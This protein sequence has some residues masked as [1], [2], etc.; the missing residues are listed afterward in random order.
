[1][2]DNVFAQR[3]SAFPETKSPERGTGPGLNPV[4]Q[5]AVDT[6]VPVN[7]LLAAVER[8][9]PDFDPEKVAR[10]T[11]T[12]LK[13]FID[14]GADPETAIRQMVGDDYAAGAL[15]DHAKKIAAQKYPLPKDGGAA[16]PA[17]DQ[18]AA[19]K[20][21]DNQPGFIGDLGRRV[22]GAVVSSGGHML[23]ATGRGLGYDRQF[24]GDFDPA[25][26]DVTMREVEADRFE[27]VVA[28]ADRWRGAGQAISD[29]VS[30][31]TKE[32]L[33]GTNIS[34]NLFKPST[35]DFG[36]A[37]SA[38]GLVMLAGDVL[39][40]LAPVVAA[41][42]ATRGSAA[43]GMV[44]GGL[45]G[46]GA[47]SDQ[48]REIVDAAAA[49]G[50]LQAESSYYKEA[51]AGGASP[52]EALQLTR[53][54]AARVAAE[55]T[56]PISMFGGAATS[57]IMSGAAGN[58]LGQK[59]GGTVAGRVGAGVVASGLEEGV[60][61]VAEGV[62]ARAA[63]NM[64]TG[65]N[66]DVMDGSFADF[67]LGAMGGGPV[68][69]IGGIRRP[70]EEAPGTEPAGPGLPAPEPTLALPP[71]D[72]SE[73]LVGGPQAPAPTPPTGGP[74]ST[75][76][77]GRDVGVGATPTGPLGRAMQSAPAPLLDDVPLGAQVSVQT[78]AGEVARGRIAAKDADSVML[79]SDDGMDFAIPRDQ[80]ESGQVRFTPM[81]RD[82]EITSDVP[83]QGATKVS[84][85]TT[86][87]APREPDPAPDRDQLERR[88]AII[89]DQGRSR[90]WTDERMKLRADTMAALAKL[91]AEGATEGT[92]EPPQGTPG[93]EY[94]V[95]GD[96]DVEVE[97]GTGP[98][99]VSVTREGPWDF[100]A[101]FPS[102][103]PQKLLA[104]DAEGRL[105]PT[106]L[107]PEAVAT[108]LMET[109]GEA[110]GRS[111]EAA[112]WADEAK[113]IREGAKPSFKVKKG[114][115]PE[116]AAEIAAGNAREAVK[117]L[118]DMEGELLSMWPEEAVQAMADR[119]GDMVKQSR[120]ETE[121]APT[122]AKAEPAPKAPAPKVE[123]PAAPVEAEDDAAPAAEPKPRASGPKFGAFKLADNLPDDSY[124]KRQ[125][126]FTGPEL[127]GSDTGYMLGELDSMARRAA[128]HL[129]ERGKEPRD[130]NKGRNIYEQG[131]AEIAQITDLAERILDAAPKDGNFD[132]E[133]ET[134]AA[135]LEE[136]DNL[137]D[138]FEGH[139][140][141]INETDTAQGEPSWNP[142]TPTPEMPAAEIFPPLK[143][144]VAIDTRLKKEGFIPQ[145]DADAL[146]ASWKETAQRI[147]DEVDN[148]KKVVVSLFDY[149]GSW[150]QPWRD[151]GYRVIQHDIKAGANVL[152]DQWI[153]DQITEAR[154]SGFEV[155]GVLSACPC[156]TFAGSGAR[157]W[158]EL[159]DVESPDA[160]AKVFG[161]GALASGAK[162]PVEYN[163]M[164][165]E[166][167][168]DVIAAAAPTRFHVL[169]NPIGRIQEKTG[170]SKPAVRLHPHNFGDAYTKR[171]QL[172]GTMKT[173]LPTANV[174]PVD[175]SKMQSQ[176]RGDDPMGKE[177]RSK[178]PE[179][180][181][182][183]F[184][185]ANDPTARKELGKPID[186]PSKAKTETPRAKPATMEEPKSQ[187][188]L[189][190]KDKAAADMEREENARRA[191]GR[192]G[193][194]LEGGY[195]ADIKEEVAGFFITGHKGRAGG[196][197]DVMDR[198]TGE[199]M[200][201]V[202]ADAPT[203]VIL[204][205]LRQLTGQQKAPAP[206]APKMKEDVV[207]TA[208][209]VRKAAAETV[210]DPSP[211]QAEA[212]NYK[213]GKIGWRGLTLSIENAK[214]S[215]RRKIG[216][217]GE[218][219]WEVKMPAHYGRILGTEGADGDHVDFYMGDDPKAE[220]AFVIDQVDAETGKFDEHKVMLGFATEADARAAYEAGF[221]DG[222]GKDRL[223]GLTAMS[224]ADFG[225]L[226]ADPA[227]WKKPLRA[228]AEK[229]K[230][231]PKDAAPDKD[232]AEYDALAGD[233]D[234][235]KAAVRDL[236]KGSTIQIGRMAYR[237]VN[238]K[239]YVAEYRNGN[240]SWQR[241]RGEK[242]QTDALQAFKRVFTGMAN[243]GIRN[244]VEA[245][246][247][248]AS[249]R[250]K[251]V[252]T[253]KDYDRSEIEDWVASGE[254]V[255]I[256][257]VTIFYK[258]ALPDR[259]RISMAVSYNTPTWSS[260]RTSIDLDRDSG[261]IAYA[262]P[263]QLHESIEEALRDQK[264]IKKDTPAET[265]GEFAGPRVLVNYVGPDGKTDQE[266]GRKLTD[267]ER[268]E[269]TRQNA[270]KAKGGKAEPKTKKRDDYM[271]GVSELELM[272][273]GDPKARQ[274]KLNK[275]YA[276]AKAAVSAVQETMPRGHRLHVK[277]IGVLQHIETTGDGKTKT[278][279]HFTTAGD[280]LE[281]AGEIFREIAQEI[282][283]RVNGAQAQKGWK[284]NKGLSL[285]KQAWANNLERGDGAGDLRG[286]MFPEL[287]DYAD[288]LAARSD[289]EL[290]RLAPQFKDDMNPFH[291]AT[292]LG[293]GG[294]EETQALFREAGIPFFGVEEPGEVT[295]KPA[296]PAKPAYGA[297]NKLVS[298]DRAAELRA[299]LMDK[300]KNQTNAGIDPEILAL[301]AE[302]AVFHIEAGARRFIDMARA[303]S[304]DLSTTPKALKPYLR[305]W[306]NGA[307]DMMEDSDV[308]VEG[309][310]SA[311]T[312]RTILQSGAIDGLEAGKLPEEGLSSMQES[313]DEDSGDD[314][315]ADAGDGGQG[316]GEGAG[317]PEARPRE[318][319][320]LRQDDRDTG[321]DGDRDAERAGDGPGADA[322]GQGA[323]DGAGSGNRAGRR[324]TP[325]DHVIERGA[326]EVSGG[327]K[328]R[329]RNSVAA[330][331]LAKEIEAE[332][333]VA[334]PEERAT[335][336][337]YGGAGTLAPALPRDDGSI[338]FEDVHA[339]IKDLLTDEEYAT[340][341]RT[342]Q[343]AFY[344][345]EPVLRGMWTLAQR[346]GFE[347]GRVFE[348]GMGVGGFAGT[349]PAAIRADTRYRGIELD[350]V[351]ALIAKTLYPRS[352]IAQGDFITMA[353][354]RDYY[355]MVIG[356][357][358]FS[359]T[360]IEAD[361]AYP[362][363]FL[364]HDY[365]FAKSL[366]SV[367]P[368]GLLMFVTSAGTMNKADT[369][370]RDYLADR[371]DL[372]GAIRLPNTA[373]K[374]N[375]TEV[376]TDIIILRKRLEG[377]AEVDPSWRKA[378]VVTLPDRDGGEGQATVNQYFIDH[379]EMILGEQGLY[380]KLAAGPRVGVRALPGADIRKQIA[381]VIERFPSQIMSERTAEQKL[382]ARDGSAT[383]TKTGGYYIKDGQLWQ[384]DGNAG[385]KVEARAKGKTGKT[386]AAID[387]IMGLVPIKMALRDVYAA[388]VAGKD[389]S[390]ARKRLNDTYDAFVKKFGPINQQVRSERRPSRVQME[391]LRQR[392][393]EDARSAGE[394]FDIGSFDAQ[395]LFDEQ[396][397]SMA[398]VA[399][400]REEARNQPGYRE[401]DFNPD[402]APANIIVTRPN[403]DP[404]M[405][406]QDGYR[407]LAIE[408]YDEVTD[409][410][411]KG[412]VFREN[413]VTKSVTPKIN[414][415]EDAL[416]FTL[417]EFGRVDLEKI[418]HY[419]K[420]D[421]PTV[422]KELA[423][424]VFRDPTTREWQTRAKYLSGNVREKLDAARAAA[425]TNPAYEG[426]VTELEAIQPD[427]IPGEQITVPIGAHWFDAG[428]Y[429]QFAEHLGLRLTATFKPAL[430]TWVVDGSEAGAKATSDYGTEDLPFAKL[431][432][433]VMNNQPLKVTRTAKNPDGST[434]SFTDETATQ[435]A[436]DK[437][438][439]MRD[440]F[441]DW[442]WSDEA[443]K[444]DL[445]DTYNRKFN[446]DVAP[447]FD[448][449]YLTTP[450]I[451]TAWQW[452]PHQ[453]AVI[454][455]ILQ[456]G[457]TYMAH[458]V[459][460][461]KT[462]AAIGA[463]MEARRLGLW[464]KPMIVVPNHMLVQ[465]TKEFYEQYPLAKIAVADEQR[466]HTSRRKAFVADIALNDYDAVIITHSAFEKI[467][468][469]EQARAA[470]VADFLSDI[471]E[472]LEQGGSGDRNADMATERSILYALTSIAKAAGVPVNSIVKEKGRSTRKKIEQIL[473]Q[474]EQRVTR[475]VSTANRDQVVDFE[476]IGVDALIVD[477]VHEFR[478][479]S[480]A[481]SMG[482][483]KGVD[484]AG[485]DKSMDLFVKTR[486][487]EAKNPG[488]GLVFMSGT[489]ITNTM[490]ELFSISRFLQPQEL[491]RRGVAS[492]DAWAATFGEVAEDLEQ[493][494]DGSYKSVARF[495][496]FVNTP[497]LSLMVRQVMDVVSSHDL[498]QYVTRPAL[499]GGSRNLV[500]VPAGPEAKAYQEQLRAR[501]EKIKNHKGPRQKGDD[502]LLNVIGDGRLAA[503][504]MR[505]VDE[506]A[507]GTGSKLSEMVEAIYREWEDGKNVPFYGVKPEGGY[508]DEP[509]SHGPATQIVFSTLG[510]NP[511][512]HNPGF[513]VHRFIRSELIRRG[514]PANEIIVA[515]ELNSHAKKQRAFNDMNEGKRRILI[516][517]RT[518]FTGVNAQ[519]RL[520][521]IHN[522][523]PLWFPADDEQRNGRGIRQG[524]MNREIA[525]NDYSTKG[526]YD[527]TM[528]QMMGRKGAFIEGF[529]RGDPNVRDIEDI[530]EASVFEQAKALTT[531]DPRV[532]QLTELKGQR[533]QL[534][535]RADAVDRQRSR[536]DGRIR[537]S[538]RSIE[539]LTSEIEAWQAAAEKVVDLK[540]KNFTARVGSVETTERVEFGRMLIDLADDALAAG[541]AARQK[542]VAKISG[543]DVLMNTSIAAQSVDFDLR[544][545]SDENIEAGWSDD[546]VG[547]SRR[548]ENA[549]AAIA[550]APA[551]IQRDI[552]RSEATVKES[553]EAL[554]RVKPFED[555][556]KLAEIE[557]QIA[558]IEGAL[559]SDHKKDDDSKE[560]AAD[561]WTEIEAEDAPDP[562]LIQMAVN[563]E[564]RAHGIKGRV[565]A[566]VVAEILSTRTGTPIP[567]VFSTRTGI[568]ISAGSGFDPTSILHHEIIH[569]L[570]SSQLWGRDYGLFDQNEWR[571]LTR[572]ARADA[573]I[574]A[575][576]NQYYPT[577]STA[578]KNEEAVAELY[579]RWRAG[580]GYEARN[581]ER[582]SGIM[583]KIS[584]FFTALASALRGE[585]FHSHADIMD[586]IARGDVGKRAR[587]DSGRFAMAGAREMAAFTDAAPAKSDA[588][589]AKKERTL[590]SNLLTQAMN[591]R[592]GVLALVPGRPLYE[593][594][595]RNIGSA[596]RYLRL[597]E[598]M[599]KVR[600]EWHERTDEVAKS[601]RKVM[602]KDRAANEAMMNLMHEATI[603][604]VD[605]SRPFLPL[606]AATDL[607]AFFAP[608]EGEYGFGAT[609]RLRAINER[610]FAA[611]QEMKP[612]WNA[613]P[614][615]FKDVFRKVRGEH[616]AMGDAF[617]AAIIENVQ[618]SMEI[619][620]D[621]AKDKY[622]K[623]IKEIA[624]MGLRGAALS[625]ATDAAKQELKAAEM[626]HGW[627]KAARI[628]Q[629][630][631][632][633]ETQKVPE[634]YFPLMRFGN[635]FVTVR[636]AEG[637]VLSFSKY[638]TEREQQ[639]AAKEAAKERG[640][641]VTTG[642]IDEDADFR[643]QVDP[644][645]VADIDEILGDAIVDPGVMD[646]IWQRWLMTLPDMSV[647]KSRIHRK[648]TA[649]YSGDAFRA[650]AR[651]LFHGSHQLARLKYAVEM[652]RELEKAET[653]AARSSDPNRNGLI[654]AEMKR[655]HDHVMNPGGSPIAQKATSAAF[656]YYLGITPSAAMVNLT[657]TT[658]V[659]TPILGA[660]FEKGGLTRAGAELSK[661][662]ADFTRGKG[663]AER[664]ARLTG[665]EKAA[666]RAA[667]DQGIV[668]ASQAHDL[669]GISET[670]T[671]YQVGWR[672]AMEV[673]S[674]SFHHAERL[675]R[676][677]TFLAAYR[678]AR[679]N[680]YAH[681]SAIQKA[682]ELT[683]KTHFDY[684]N[685]SRPRLMQNDWLRVFMV[686][687]NFQINMLW[688]L[689]R[690]VHQATQG[691][692][693]EVRREARAQLIG[694]TTSMFL[695][696]GVRGVWGYSL[697]LTMMSM[698]GLGEKDEIE[699]EIKGALYKLF[700]R[701]V[702]GM[703]FNG[704]PGH[705]LGIDLSSRIGM[706]ELW[707][708]SSD[709]MLE[710]Q[711]VY[712]H[713]LEQ[714]VGAVPA[715]GSN[716][717]KGVQFISEG[718]V[719]RGIEAVAPKAI[720]DLMVAGRYWSEGVQAYSGY[721]V[722][723]EVSPRE[724]ITKALGFSPARVSERYRVNNHLVNSEK[725]IDGRRDRL[726]ADARQ[727]LMDGKP[728]SQRTL[729]KIME[730]NRD[731][732]EWMITAKSIRQSLASKQRYE[733][734]REGGVRINPK[735]ERR[736][737]E[738]VAPMIYD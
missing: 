282:A 72:T 274:D 309:M 531:S 18:A 116:E 584:R 595:G 637:R 379:P 85:P 330:I 575:W 446:G 52:E 630:R 349:V 677:V 180:F 574:M 128:A 585:G 312:V 414:S 321:A 30:D 229:P 455:R 101:T 709:R 598:R 622:E 738:G 435:A 268:A 171:T 366:D 426:N 272:I 262:S 286:S 284:G 97:D 230:A 237:L 96:F 416:L 13:P 280:N 656:V 482:S 59:I 728:I 322:D 342:S 719:Y 1:M 520:R 56:M 341:S 422:Q 203:G 404:F 731:Y 599:D 218:T 317:D 524:N 720:R 188:D 467:P 64:A 65:L 352:E 408:H 415:P 77:G 319:G 502:I 244:T 68:G 429:S 563:N 199:I 390:E 149:T 639:K 210:K 386:K 354:P 444:A 257:D 407:L 673:I 279:E 394:D 263:S 535:R 477:E 439:E 725:R 141:P 695:H 334:S 381:E 410:A 24:E 183:A 640:V 596:K 348:P 166:A 590:I 205:K 618:K 129:Y 483:I 522:L 378:P 398:E 667:Y 576:V 500:V 335:I 264:S 243:R 131:F 436:T 89:E 518:L 168:R 70:E 190:G 609:E 207:P 542:V 424:K 246:T 323:G 527:S 689:F 283:D 515:D 37:P 185:M 716:V 373:F 110:F 165:Y 376:T 678:M 23:E 703:M 459:G 242:K 336:A 652:E 16:G 433:K 657:Q 227:K 377:E 438:R 646:A 641:N 456:D 692:S 275:G 306:Y 217:D 569:A 364:M 511:T 392:A 642:V 447:S 303:I 256:G 486:S 411:K 421:V 367:R 551:R 293:N 176:M 259:G 350:H 267:E 49:D 372:V 146:V 160:V 252:V 383:E 533:D 58:V 586:R 491:R 674:F 621:R 38:R 461:G 22:A 304:G 726:L 343:Y 307:R 465:F 164:L 504:D 686:F 21:A 623:A 148:S 453:S 82:T 152:T 570:R 251:K 604:G 428:I 562:R 132:Q 250:D 69:A 285:F 73:G 508:T 187:G 120:A 425:K 578:A 124:R 204:S 235:W 100:E 193:G 365:F 617:E 266:R 310:D 332:G 443:R 708:R 299:R 711:D 690:D 412:P 104:L 206:I 606:G 302:L 114:T 209:D 276:D 296:K 442:L 547:L 503:I 553:T 88:L 603:A 315:R 699:E 374:E 694:I 201:K 137:R 67:V 172:F 397:K 706:P 403:L 121:T 541:V 532:L 102:P 236:R 234:A 84:P 448:G 727:A 528:W 28:A 142:D 399:A 118:E 255:T 409:T 292:H 177:N 98:G 80:I 393:R 3:P 665:D 451:N 644:S 557:V 245:F 417:A 76:P 587:D 548:L 249:A 112:E 420:S 468:S 87:P 460:A 485:S 733:G 232:G 94:N 560:M 346:L 66:E 487:V 328:T 371:A 671:E 362:Q 55:M 189:F 389:S 90:G 638:E 178:T 159:H 36:D 654:V 489:P 529:F 125:A 521:A 143:S 687:R 573:E 95:V 567:G 572:A 509:V 476:E 721:E 361:P 74:N 60:Q 329:A 506:N 63:T 499:K 712:A 516:G 490:A 271:A 2:A 358:P 109:M 338:R 269:F 449:G 546:P 14:K 103:D 287:A 470:A 613:L 11:A 525:I 561:G 231:E 15:I 6:G 707:F 607:D 174:E 261:V 387:R 4:E 540:G 224:V 44:A 133:D 147:G 181:A 653:E 440:L 610:R 507:T 680:G 679:K 427:P 155:V 402:A 241:I 169:E 588:A 197:L 544:A 240:G 75:Q 406:D 81:Q 565:P 628:K 247:A 480:F 571:A 182:Y 577:L 537:S 705:M 675:N 556:D 564:M 368:G 452:R 672:R 413:V 92:M 693:P 208:T 253:S 31:R 161:S 123:A 162:S 254:A 450:G 558:E 290:D 391:T 655:R 314:N 340:L 153:Y 597:K 566:R 34:G 138:D 26:G 57:K 723:P 501:M 492:F 105:D 32:A 732:P 688:R 629:L 710:G 664:S 698:L 660:A 211:A 213:T 600:N 214:G 20:D 568:E 384:F 405:E 464:K 219:A 122:E 326:L 626:R 33:Q 277:A 301:G 514:V 191:F 175:G 42:V 523:D 620:L 48:A 478:K 17:P 494:P 669:A 145:E 651:A 289:A 473:E 715:I 713:W 27:D 625:E 649:G 685:T 581:G 157:W 196:H 150:A 635:F 434:T 225:A 735:I 318:A 454:A 324:V 495:A 463:T 471:R 200:G 701:H 194:M 353:P 298:T 497:E 294:L 645:F 704:I 239:E 273:G 663:K 339:D 311:E 484:A 281:R 380:E 510:V 356:N 737:R 35:W 395:P 300:L 41:T 47:A 156:T 10:N 215:M 432:R 396:G 151:A 496:R 736:V 589:Y 370:A 331:R 29:S 534:K 127:S 550:E 423:G 400:A 431:M 462:S 684:Q 670:G 539:F 260:D 681:D 469:S 345:A 212:E 238:A 170:L 549:V 347:G 43:A 611:W 288:W 179:G 493:E 117:W 45:Q 78:E 50:R 5:I 111:S 554:A 624:D 702:A 498:D 619:G 119:L 580:G 355:D 734:Q 357:P 93:S 602:V 545:F 107:D 126:K 634:P 222:K 258:A 668:D 517:S 608:D 441:R 25:T 647:R 106:I 248:P 631:S 559:I 61:E 278:T 186:L 313:V 538:R 505:L 714:L 488:R 226:I 615:E 83:P 659:G 40:S 583:D 144:T 295:A 662:L 718:E 363:K 388:D 216:P 636:D 648:G 457:N 614:A 99:K 579:R 555:S 612:K 8:A 418:A 305:S 62:S 316:P 530:G 474:A 233:G 51:I 430:G 7:V 591:G 605:P 661:A 19:P 627:N 291:G 658:V 730:F 445:E 130:I 594:L 592:G 513:S 552:A 46:S 632:I 475:Q 167:T 71:P 375:G 139:G 344:T 717:I 202:R 676:E 9:G 54:A 650:Y 108:S 582:L 369:K 195:L 351:T 616:K 472:L 700:G 593:E 643:D 136:F 512:K 297:D 220:R 481:T 382:D 385:V 223:G 134:A 53:E 158:E 724:A 697:I 333:R 401:G 359:G 682:G 184:F 91:D 437:A 163:V 666:M 479:L 192:I 337:L 265:N 526:T 154:Q 135:L 12:R 173:D 536:L 140:F 270:E 543:F 466:F 729:D 458:T 320:S 228:K 360:R 722:L 419:A 86:K 39:G 327:E 113:R 696:A 691:D 601:W 633:F 519:R 115:S 79:K 198:D 221:S 308:S 683:Y 325:Q